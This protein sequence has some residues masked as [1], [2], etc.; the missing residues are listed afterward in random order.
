MALDII[1][2][3]LL[4]PVLYSRKDCYRQSPN[5]S[6]SGVVVT[7]VS[8]VSTVPSVPVPVSYRAAQ[9]LASSYITTRKCNN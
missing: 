2:P 4:V 5:F 8:G 9:L 1:G 3:K 6:P 7:K